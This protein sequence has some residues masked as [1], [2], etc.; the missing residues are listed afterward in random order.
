MNNQ[1]IIDFIKPEKFHNSRDVSSFNISNEQRFVKMLIITLNDIYM[2][3]QRIMKQY[4]F[5]KLKEKCKDL[6]VQ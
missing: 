4:Q 5:E 6:I 2:Q 3:G 1:D